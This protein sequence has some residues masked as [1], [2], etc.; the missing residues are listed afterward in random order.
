[1]TETAKHTTV[2][3]DGVELNPGFNA[4]EVSKLP[5]PIVEL[6]LMDNIH[7]NW[8]EGTMSDGTADSTSK[9]EARV[10]AKALRL[11]L[12]G[13]LGQ[14]SRRDSHYDGDE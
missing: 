1:M 2:V 14:N 5:N 6:K 8:S 4:V 12:G 10:E 13:G 3:C 9:S 7:I 11:F